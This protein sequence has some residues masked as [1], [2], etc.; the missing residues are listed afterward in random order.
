MDGSSFSHLSHGL[1]IISCD[2]RLSLRCVLDGS[3]GSRKCGTGEFPPACMR[4]WRAGQ[5]SGIPGWR[6]F[7]RLFFSP[8]KPHKS[9]QQ[10]TFIPPTPAFTALLDI[11]SF[12]DPALV[13]LAVVEGNGKHEDGMGGFALHRR[14]HDTNITARIYFGTHMTLSLPSLFPIS[15]AES[16]GWLAGWP[17]GWL[18]TSSARSHH[19]LVGPS[20]WLVNVDRGVLFP[21]ASLLCSSSPWVR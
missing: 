11:P 20:W 5:K 14:F 3:L 21:S 4:L 2:P 16:A 10:T 7:P 6:Y 18:V 19:L 13:G 9:P 15:A 12:P 17:R 8:I 1:T